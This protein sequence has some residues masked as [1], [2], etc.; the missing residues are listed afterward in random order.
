VAV[1][2]YLLAENYKKYT[3]IVIAC[4]LN[5]PKIYSLLSQVMGYMH[6]GNPLFY[7]D[8]ELR[9]QAG[10][11]HILIDDMP[12]APSNIVLLLWLHLDSF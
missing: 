5:A 8:V 4:D 2:Y 6:V 12:T 10:R 3:N 7:T 1:D 9:F 11:S